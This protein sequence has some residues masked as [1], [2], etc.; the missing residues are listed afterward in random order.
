MAGISTSTRKLWEG[1]V[2]YVETEK[3]GDEICARFEIHGY[4]LTNAI[5][6]M[7]EKGIKFI[8]AK[9]R[10]HLDMDLKDAMKILKGIKTDGRGECSGCRDD[11]KFK[12]S[13][14]P[15]FVITSECQ[16]LYV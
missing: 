11:K 5:A 2:E 16:S 9:K 8:L 13:T 15:W 4:T 10:I 6:R 3:R 7:R 1:I 14:A 12:H